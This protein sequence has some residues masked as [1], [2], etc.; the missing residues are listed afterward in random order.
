MKRIVLATVALVVLSAGSLR[1]GAVVPQFFPLD[2]DHGPSPNTVTVSGT[3]C[4]TQAQDFLSDAA[5]IILAGPP[6]YVGGTAY[7]QL[8]DKDDP[9]D[10]IGPEQS[11]PA[12]DTQD[13][14]WQGTFLIPA[15]LAPGTYTVRARCDVSAFGPGPDD[16]FEYQQVRTYRVLGERGPGDPVDLE[17]TFTG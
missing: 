1:A 14:E 8:F 11:Y 6:L 9:D 10:P 7:V 16:D 2:P 13:G 12:E 5:G 4:S 3:R 15:G 17:P